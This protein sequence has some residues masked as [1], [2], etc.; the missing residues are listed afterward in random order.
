M[1]R[2]A[3][4]RYE[5]Q[6]IPTFFGGT[7]YR[8]KTEARW[9]V[10]FD[11]LEVP[12]KYEDEGF[13]IKTDD[14]EFKYLPDFLLPDLEVWPGVIEIKGTPPTEEEVTKLI[15]VCDHKGCDGMFLIG[16]PDLLGSVIW[17]IRN[18]RGA[19]DLYHLK[20]DCL[21]VLFGDTDRAFL[22]ARSYR[23]ERGHDAARETLKSMFREAA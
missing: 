23:F 18:P 9:A 7:L 20:Q 2:S 19:Y 3:V 12:F 4:K 8:S 1:S 21:S 15:G 6:A 22:V 10:C 11:V 16:W 17:C 13:I 14:E 5:V